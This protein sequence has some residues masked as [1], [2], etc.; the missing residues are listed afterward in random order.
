MSTAHHADFAKFLTMMA[1][2]PDFLSQAVS[3]SA[4]LQPGSTPTPEAALEATTPVAQ[5]RTSSRATKGVAAT[6]F[7]PDDEQAVSR[8]ETKAPFNK[9]SSVPGKLTTGAKAVTKKRNRDEINPEPAAG[10]AKK[11]KKN[12]IATVP[13]QVQALADA[14]VTTT[15]P[16]AVAKRDQAANKKDKSTKPFKW[17]A[18]DPNHEIRHELFKLYST[19]CPWEVVSQKTDKQTGVTKVKFAVISDAKTTVGSAFRT[20]YESHTELSQLTDVSLF[21][22]LEREMKNEKERLD[23]M[24]KLTG[25]GD[26]DDETE[27]S[28]AYQLVL[29]EL[30]HQRQTVEDVKAKSKASGSANALKLSAAGKVALAAAGEAAKRFGRAA[31][32]DP[33]NDPLNPEKDDDDEEDD[34]ESLS[35]SFGDGAVEDLSVS[36]KSSVTTTKPKA[37]VR[38]QTL[39]SKAGL[40]AL[41]ASQVE[42]LKADREAMAERSRQLEIQRENEEKAERAAKISME[43]QRLDNE[44]RRL[45]QQQDRDSRRDAQQQATNMMQQA[46]LALLKQVSP[47][48]GNP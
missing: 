24:T 29:Q 1:D 2:N 37:R 14:Y 5:P 16:Q 6:P 44:T 42:I 8:A 20:L 30:L 9:T 21:K 3:L 32:P 18:S 25:A 31:G 12:A 26:D 40:S 15:S 7:T 47:Q 45:Q 33:R 4:A 48:V 41:I 19:H 27:E 36:R 38:G 46:L 43:Q 13:S 17:L 23:G 39:N 34:N 11:Q 28:S 35:A 22:C 10:K